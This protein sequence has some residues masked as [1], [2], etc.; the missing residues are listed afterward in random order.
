MSQDTG[1]LAWLLEPENP[2]VRYLALTG[3]LGRAPDDPEAA[4]ARNAIPLADPARAIL[5]AQYA[6]SAHQ[7]SGYWVKPDVG[8]SPKYRAT[9]WQVLFL[10]QLGAPP[11]EPIRRACDY[12]LDHSRRLRDRRGNPDGRFVAGKEAHTAVNCLNGN[13]LWA[14][15]WLGYGADPR[16]LEARQATARAI[17]ERGFGCHYNAGLPCAW[18]AVK[19]LHALLEVPGGERLAAVQSA[20]GRGVELLLSVPL[21]EASYPAPGPV[22]RRWFQLGFPLGY[23]ADLLEA[24]TV[25]VRAGYGDHPHV[26]A[27]LEWLLEKRDARGRWTLEQTPGKMWASFGRVGQPNKWVTLRALICLSEAAGGQCL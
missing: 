16:T 24:M 3:L 15:G 27:G 18:G 13:L 4:S 22:S 25:L 21:L 26:Q 19:V 1:A 23:Q 11:V 5:D 10:A 14:L 6:G 9:V 7:P 12:V 8:Y 17:V 2:S 20:I